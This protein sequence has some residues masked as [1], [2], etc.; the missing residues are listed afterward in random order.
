MSIF[1]KD[2]SKILIIRT[3]TGEVIKY[4]SGCTK[5]FPGDDTDTL[6]TSDFSDTSGY[7]TETILK[8]APYDRVN[9]LVKLDC[10]TPG[11]KRKYM[12]KVF[13]NTQ[14]WYVCDNCPIRLSGKDI[15]LTL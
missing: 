15:S 2:C 6:I 12:T 14:V 9:Q 5:E 4:C 8:Y 7:N 3:D 11:C 1:C 13:L 10:P